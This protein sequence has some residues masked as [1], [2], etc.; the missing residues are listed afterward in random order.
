MERESE[1][2]IVTTVPMPIPNQFDL[3]VSVRTGSRKNWKA[4]V[5]VVQEEDTWPILRERIRPHVAGDEALL[6]KVPY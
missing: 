5:V 4:F 1:R 3:H 2:R 6:R